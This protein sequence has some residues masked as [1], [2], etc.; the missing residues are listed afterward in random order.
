MGGEKPRQQAMRANLP[1]PDYVRMNG[2]M[3]PDAITAVGPEDISPGS[4]QSRAAE[5]AGE[6]GIAPMAAIYSALTEASQAGAK[7]VGGT[8]IRRS[9]QGIPPEKWLP[10]LTAPQIRQAYAAKVIT[11]EQMTAAI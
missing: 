6:R 5:I 4:I 2:M 3:P 8:D 11:H 1:S 7:T 10:Q 9:L